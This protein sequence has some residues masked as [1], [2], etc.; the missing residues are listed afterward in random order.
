MLIYLCDTLYKVSYHVLS[1]N[2]LCIEVEYSAGTRPTQIGQI[3]SIHQRSKHILCSVVLLHTCLM[4]RQQNYW[5]AL[6]SLPKCQILDFFQTEWVS[7][8]KFKF[9]EDGIKFFK[10]VEDTVGEGE[11]THYEQLSFSTGLKKKN[12]NTRADR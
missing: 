2:W 1:D 6:L 12:I 10:W 9:N 7:Y 11:I 3:D 5:E 4:Q 8:D